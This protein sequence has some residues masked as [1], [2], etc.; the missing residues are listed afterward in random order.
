MGAKKLQFDQKAL[1]Q[2][3]KDFNNV[4]PKGIQ[5]DIIKDLI[6]MSLKYI[7]INRSAMGGIIFA[8]IKEWQ[9]QHKKELADL[10]K[11]NP[12]IRIQ[13]VTLIMQIARDRLT[14]MLALVSQ[15]DI[16]LRA[17]ENAKKLY[18]EKYARR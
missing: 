8:A 6:D 9:K 12:E 15:S 11:A 16:V 10:E 17:F 14:N 5:S 3:E 7:S 18:I 13:E 1:D 2:A 4:F